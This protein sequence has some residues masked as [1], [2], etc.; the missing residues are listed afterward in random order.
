MTKEAIYIY[1]HLLKYEGNIMI[2]VVTKEGNIE[3]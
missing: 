1:N 3:V 2:K